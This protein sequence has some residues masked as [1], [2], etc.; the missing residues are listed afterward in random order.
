M[1]GST[2]CTT[3]RVSKSRKW[4]LLGVAITVEALLTI[5]ALVLLGVLAYLFI[6]HIVETPVTV[7]LTCRCSV[8]VLQVGNTTLLSICN[9]GTVTIDK[10]VLVY[11]NST[12]TYSVEISEGACTTLTLTQTQVPKLVQCF[13]T[14]GKS[15]IVNIA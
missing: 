11:S 8:T 12:L 1:A 2:S 5:L 3:H 14:N 13:C 7:A 10:L 4:T 6:R 9:A 15:S